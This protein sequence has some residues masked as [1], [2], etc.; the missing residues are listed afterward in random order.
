M[1]PLVQ[2]LGPGTQLVKMD[3]KEAYRIVTVHPDDQHLLA[4][5]WNGSVYVDRS[6]PLGL[7]LAPKIF[8]AVAD[9]AS[10]GRCL[11]T[12]STRNTPVADDFL[13]FQ[14]RGDIL[15]TDTRT[16]ASSVFQ[17]LGVPVAEHKTEGPSTRVTFLGFAIDT[18]MFQ[19]SLM[20]DKLLRLQETIALWQG[21]RGCTQKELESLLG[22]LSHVAFAICPGR[23]FLRQLFA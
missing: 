8:T 16:I 3:L 4:I 11:G 1:K 7:R 19:L 17:E 13:F 22:C 6:L 5:T 23:L 14:P 10:C 9:A 2:A 12:P 20:D 15:S 18:R 21:R